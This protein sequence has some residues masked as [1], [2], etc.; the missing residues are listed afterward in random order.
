MS[1]ALGGGARGGRAGSDWH[2]RAAARLGGRWSLRRQAAGARWPAVGTGRLGGGRV[3]SDWH[4]GGRDASC[5]EDDDVRA[6]WRGWLSPR[7]CAPT[8]KPGDDIRCRCTAHGKSWESAHPTTM[9]RIK[10]AP[11]L[12]CAPHSSRLAVP[13][14]T[15]EYASRV[16]LGR[17]HATRGGFRTPPPA[18]RVLNCFNSAK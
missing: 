5:D 1:P 9:A 3:G 11:S 8:R 10:S 17:L 6:A 18:S 7:D 15:T 12:W 2:C 13:R 14:S 16:R 4:L